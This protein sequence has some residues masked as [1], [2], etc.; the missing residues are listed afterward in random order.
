MWFGQAV[1]YLVGIIRGHIWK[2]DIRDAIKSTEIYEFILYATSLVSLLMSSSYLA[3]FSYVLA[4]NIV[5][6][7]CIIPDHDTYESTIENDKETNDWC[8]MQIRKSGNFC[9]ESVLFT[10]LH[11]GINYQI[12]HHL[13]PSMC[14]R[15]YRLISPIVQ[16]YCA[17]NKIPYSCK[18]NL[19]EVYKS[20]TK[21]LAYMK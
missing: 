21:M 20:Y 17:D 6:S 18:A 5:Y 10:E 7:I 2:L 14:H 15:Y 19:M 13:F 16:K 3:V 8:E 1:A 12:E 11:G 4:L 9:N